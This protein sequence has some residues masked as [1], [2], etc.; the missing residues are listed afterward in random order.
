MPI[1]SL[2][3]HNSSSFNQNISKET[4][5]KKIHL[6]QLNMTVPVHNF[7]YRL[8]SWEDREQLKRLGLL[9]YGQY[10]GV[11]TPEN[12]AMLESILNDENRLMDLIHN[13]L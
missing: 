7:T 12:W 6:Y 11:L 4:D 10:S 5:P 13:I 2:F 9:A 1:R 8:G 3:F